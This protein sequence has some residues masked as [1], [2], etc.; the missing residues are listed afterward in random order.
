MFA[1][2]DRRL[3]GSRLALR[4]TILL[5]LPVTAA[6]LI[7]LALVAVTATIRPGE[8]LNSVDTFATGASTAGTVASSVCVVVGF[9]LRRRNPAT[10]L[11]WYQRAVLVDLLVTR[12]FAFALDEFAAIVAVLIDLVMLAVLGRARRTLHQP[13]PTG[14][15]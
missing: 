10:A 12:V 9:V 4:I 13:A 6:T 8:Q 7:S 15:S 14:R 11:G 5:L 1:V 3:F 2:I